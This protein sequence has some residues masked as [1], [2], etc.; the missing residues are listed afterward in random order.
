MTNSKTK[1]NST[2]SQ[3]DQNSFDKLIAKDTEIEIKLLWK[4]V[5]PVYQKILKKQASK[6]KLKGFRKGK[7]P[8]AVA[9]KE[10][11]RDSIIN[12]VLQELIPSVYSNEIKKGKYL[13]LTN[14]EFQ[15][16]SLNKDNDWIL[17][18]HFAQEPEIDLKNYKKITKSAK[19]KAEDQIKK[20]E[21]EAKKIKAKKT[22]TKK[23]TNNKDRN[24]PSEMTQEQKNDSIVQGVIAHL[25]EEI[26]PTVPRLLLKESAQKE[27]ESFI[28]KLGSL[29]IDLETFLKSRQMTQE[30]LSSQIMMSTLSQLQIEFTL[31]AIGKSEN[32]EIDDVQVQNAIAKTEDEKIKQQMKKDVSYQE[33]L[34]QMLFKQKVIKF[35]LDL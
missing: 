12:L 7:V 11:G 25:V 8:L 30:Q 1:T 29:K 24:Q 9:E 28:K 33:Y 34:R 20:T 22:K 13:P 14:P 16:I 2:K 17:K 4:D 6:L 18:A 27:M 10:I 15:P 35:L 5:K 3:N 26:Q 23:T 31:R 21:K 32:I 19:K